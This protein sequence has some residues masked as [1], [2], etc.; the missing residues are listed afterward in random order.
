MQGLKLCEH[1]WKLIEFDDVYTMQRVIGTYDTIENALKNSH[2]VI[3]PIYTAT[4]KKIN[5][6]KCLI[7]K[8]QQKYIGAIYIN[9]KLVYLD[10]N[11]DVFTIGIR[12]EWK[13][14]KEVIRQLC[15]FTSLLEK[16][17]CWSMF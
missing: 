17:T 3:L 10:P 1:G 9:D 13:S 7:L 14:K 16:P 6:Y 5:G 2:N 12:K 4:N 11:T 8:N 15:D